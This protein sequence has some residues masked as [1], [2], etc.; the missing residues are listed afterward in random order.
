LN[1]QASFQ[2]R[3]R[4]VIRINPHN[5]EKPRERENDVIRDPDGV[6]FLQ[7][8]L[9]RLHLRWLGFRRVRRQ[10]YKRLNRRMHDLGLAGLDEYRAYLENH[11]AEW[12]ILDTLCW[13]SISRFYR[14]KGVFQYLERD[15]FPQLT[16]IALSDAEKKL[17]CWSAGCAAG[18]EPYTLAILWKHRLAAQFPTL[19]TQIVVT[20]ID[21][22]ALRRAERGCYLASSLKDLPQEWLTLAFVPTE[23]GLCL[24]AEYR[25][26]V[27]F[28]QQD[29]RETAPA[30]PFHLILCRYLVFTYF[31]EALQREILCRMTERLIP[32]GA[33]VIGAT[34]TL[35]EDMSGLVL[36]SKRRLGIYRKLS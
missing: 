12:A 14:D 26:V 25:E 19:G 16:R 29:L 33:L 20:D 5:Q 15:I 22:Q 36:W 9:P 30:G 18:E 27:T 23:E 34:E 3:Q 32:G 11:P 28:L 8:C 21:P 13:I 35:P 4:K 17:R 10:V 7:W 2:E 6:Q 1:S 24:R 31:D